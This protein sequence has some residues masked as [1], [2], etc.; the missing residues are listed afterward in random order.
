MRTIRKMVSVRILLITCDFQVIET[1]CHFAQSLAVHIEA[2]CDAESAVGKLCHSK[3]EGVMIDSA[4]PGG[5]ELLRKLSTLTSNK[6][7]IS[8]AI[9][10]PGYDQAQAFDAGAQFVLDRPLVPVA[11]LRLLK[12]AYPIMVQERRRYYRC[13]LQIA[14]FVSRG[15]DQ[16]FTVNSLNVSESGICLNSNDPMQ[17]GDKLRLRLL[18]PGAAELLNL[19]GEVAW[20]AATGRVGVRFSDVRPGVAL[21]L[22]NWLAERLEENAL[23]QTDEVEVSF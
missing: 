11:V 15:G 19:C 4:L 9:L 18:L 10:S 23:P 3:F 1:L 8:Y 22:R 17:V 13:P 12:A 21:V 5:P 14:V 2:C 16:E 6:S 7:A 20:S